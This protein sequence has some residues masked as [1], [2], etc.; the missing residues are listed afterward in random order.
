MSCGPRT[1]SL[2]SSPTEEIEMKRATRQDFPSGWN[3]KKVLA[4]IAH[5]DRQTEEEAA[6]EIE[7]RRSGRRDLDVRAH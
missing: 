7:R 4:A 2:S 5:Y 1:E 3:K 6:A